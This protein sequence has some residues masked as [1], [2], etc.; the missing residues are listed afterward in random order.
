MKSLPKFMGEW[1]LIA[2]EHIKY[3]D[4][5]VDILGIEN[6]DL[7]TRLLV[8]NFEGQVRTWFIGLLVGSMPSYN[9]LE[10]SFIRQWGEKKDHLYYLTKFRALRNKTSK[11][12]LDFIQRFNNLYHTILIEVKPSQPTTKF[13]FVGAIDSDFGLL[14][15]ERRFNTLVGIQDDSIEIE[16][17]MMASGRLKT[18][19]DTGTREPR[20]FEEHA[21]PS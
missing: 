7:Y 14:L 2:K 13:T 1:D 5:F 17:N 9:D 6:G 12:V 19:F 15:R 11:S 8:Q 16:S 10:T 3:F 18:K 21:G 20:C 4:Q